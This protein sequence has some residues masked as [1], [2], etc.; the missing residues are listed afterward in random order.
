MEWDTAAG[1]AVLR[2]AGGLTTTFEGTPLSYG[3]RANE[4]VTGFANPNFVAFGGGTK[5]VLLWFDRFGSKWTQHL[6]L[7]HS[8]L[9]AV[10][11]FQVRHLKTTRCSCSLK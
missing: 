1:D 5:P 6:S 9:K 3:Q 8:F 10:S 11:N 2:A 4:G 7:I